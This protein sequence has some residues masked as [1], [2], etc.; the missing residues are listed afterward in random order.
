MIPDEIPGSVVPTE[1]L[2]PRNL[3]A[4]KDA[5]DRKAKELAGLFKKNAGKFEMPDEVRSAGPAG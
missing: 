2:D 4:D 3:W 5:Y 1:I